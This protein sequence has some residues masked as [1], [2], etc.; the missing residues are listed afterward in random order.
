MSRFREKDLPEMLQEFNKE[1]T[2]E[3]KF[4]DNL[5]GIIVL[6]DVTIK[7]DEKIGFINIKG[8]ET[9]LTINTT[10]VY[11]YE[12]DNNIIKIVLESLIIYMKKIS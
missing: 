5:S 10:L 8:K 6:K 1:C 11:L 7:Y 9:N 2:V 12:K 3:L 4:E